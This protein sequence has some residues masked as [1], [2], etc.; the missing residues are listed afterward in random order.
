MQI[1]KA[2]RADIEAGVHQP[3]D[4]LP[5]LSEL[6]R[7]YGCSRATVREALG[8][9][10]GQGLIEFRHGDGTYVK[11]ALVDLWMDPLD[12][13]VLL[14]VGQVRELVELQIAVIAAVATRLAEAGDEVSTR[15]AP[16][17]FQVECASPNSE[18]AIAAE[19][20]FYLGMAELAGNPLLENVVRVMQESF[21]SCLRLS[22]G[23]EPLG[24]ET[25]RAVFDAISR[26]RPDLAREA[27]YT[28]G[29]GIARRLELK[30]VQGG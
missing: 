2:I 18:E 24:L 12:A 21:R 17:L 19:L 26:H 29:R 9:L 23:P 27:V 25:C 10:R 3:G 7:Q 11:T 22:F 30:R 4:R 13:A 28:Y 15:L 16:L 5:P 1:A 6:A 14:G 8:T 20:G